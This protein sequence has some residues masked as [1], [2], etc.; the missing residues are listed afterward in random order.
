MDKE[1]GLSASLIQAD[2]AFAAKF[3]QAME[4]GWVD[5]VRH[6]ELP[7]G[8]P[9][10]M[11]GDVLK[12]SSLWDYEPWVAE[13]IR[14]QHREDAEKARQLLGTEVKTTQPGE[15]DGSAS[16]TEVHPPPNATWSDSE[17]D[18]AADRRP[19]W[20]PGQASNDMCSATQSPKNGRS[21]SPRGISHS[22]GEAPGEEP[23]LP[24]AEP[25]SDDPSDSERQVD[26]GF[27][28]ERDVDRHSD[29]EREVDHPSDS[30]S[31]SGEEHTP[32]P[33]PRKAGMRSVYIASP[34]KPKLAPQSS[35]SPSLTPFR[36]S[37]KRRPSDGEVKDWIREALQ[38]P[39]SYKGDGPMDRA[40]EIFDSV[41]QMA[42]RKHAVPEAKHI[43]KVLDAQ[44]VDSLKRVLTAV[45]ATL[46][47]V[48]NRRL[49]SKGQCAWGQE[50]LEL[51]HGLGG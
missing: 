26:D 51:L 19:E 25:D 29:T 44:E 42:D 14:R 40:Q 11:E 48:R 33:R 22:D 37:P 10:A 32:P 20:E 50:V 2:K 36:S 16:P 35:H 28:S 3:L 38:I 15:S 27:D 1:H 30:E 9:E 21:Q 7:E 41:V 17:L 12:D 31:E 8:W 39:K 18:I 24:V 4:D 23:V 13:A 43:M 45:C 49:Q 5:F 46:V 6:D 34:R 47:H